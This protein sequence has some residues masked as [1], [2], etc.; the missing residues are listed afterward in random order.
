MTVP[1]SRPDRRASSVGDTPVRVLIASSSR[2]RCGSLLA[3][4]C[5]PSDPNGDT[6]DP[7]NSRTSAADVTQTA[8]YSRSRRWHPADDADVTGPGTAPNGRPSVDACPA[9]NKL[10][11][12]LLWHLLLNPAA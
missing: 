7:Y 9:G 12:L 2:M 11:S 1:G 3:C 5:T 8:S 10:D 4:V 6:R